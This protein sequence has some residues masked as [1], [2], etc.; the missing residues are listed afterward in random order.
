MK[1]AP[2]VQRQT[3]SGRLTSFLA[4][5]S[6]LS[7]FAFL[8]APAAPPPAAPPWYVKKATWSETMAASRE[9]LARRPNAAA[10]QPIPDFGLADF[11]ATAWIR[12]TRGGAILAKARPEGR[13]E[14][15]GKAF[16]VRGGKLCFDIG[17][18]GAVT[19][20]RTVGDGKWHHV[21]V[22]KAGNT[23]KLF[24][25]GRPDNSRALAAQGDIDGSVL[26]LGNASSDFPQPH[27]FDGD[28]DEIR[29]YPR[30]LSDAELLA[31]AKGTPAAQR[32]QPAAAWPM[33]G[34]TRNAMAGA[35]G[36]V[37]GGQAQKYVA[38]KRGQALHL[39]G[40]GRVVVP[41]ED[42]A[43]LWAQLEADFPS[44][45]EAQQM[46]WEREDGIWNLTWNAGAWGELARRY[47]AATRREGTPADALSEEP[48][49]MIKDEDGVALERKA[50]Y[51]ARAREDYL[52]AL[53]EM[54]L[55]GLKKAIQAMAEDAQSRMPLL[56]GAA[57][58][59]PRQGRPTLALVYDFIST[60]VRSQGAP[61]PA[62][63][64]AEFRRE[65]AQLRREIL[66]KN[67]PLIDF[68]KILFF[69]RKTSQANHYYT[70]FINGCK[71]FGVSLCT[72][73]LRDGKVAEILPESMRG[74]IITHF[75]LSCDARRIVFDYK[76]EIGK[77]FRIYEIGVDGG[78]LRQLTFDPPDEAERIHKY[79]FDKA[80]WH[81][82]D[83]MQPCYL[84]GGAICFVSTRCEYGILCDAPDLFT[85]TILYRMDK[86]GRG[87]TPL[88]NSSVSET[89]PS[90]MND[91]RILYTRW[92]YVDKGGSAVKC[93]WA[94]RPDGTGSVE[95][96]GNDINLPDTFHQ[97]RAIP[98][99]DN[100]FVC[101]G[102]PHMPFGV[103]TVLRLDINHPLRTR[104]PMTYLTPEL[105][106]T[107]EFG[108]TH[109]RGGKWV[110]DLKGPF[111]M[112]PYPLSENF[113]LVT[114]NPDREWSD[115]AGYALT[116]L[117]AFGNKVEIYRDPE[118]SCWEP[119][120][121]RPRP[122]PPVLPSIVAPDPAAPG[123]GVLTLN[124]VYQGMEGVARGTV[125]YL[126]VMEQVP[127]PW[128]SRR[129]WQ[130][131]LKDATYQEHA[132]I[133]LDG[134]L[135]LKVLRGIVPVE[136]DGSA[137]FTVPANRNLYFQALDENFMEVQRMRTYV[138]LRA[139]ES[140]SCIGCHQ[141]RGEAPTPQ[142]PLAMRRAP[143]PLAP[144]PGE[145]A[146][147]V[148]DYRL[149]VQPI[150]DRHCIQCHGGAAPKAGLDLHG[151]MTTLFSASYENLMERKAIKYI[152]E[153]TPKT[154]N[155]DYLPPYSLGAAVS[156]LVKQLKAGHHGVKL[157]RE[158]WVKLTTWADANVQYY[159][160][161]YGKRNLAFKGDPDFRPNPTFEDAISR[162]A[163]QWVK[164][165]HDY[166]ADQ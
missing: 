110:Q 8:T 160:S 48:A 123:E 76:P 128:A 165:D 43:A 143:S 97:G 112:D 27:G 163:P 87:I 26:I 100:L 61:L 13:W 125:K 71:Y 92:E 66:L 21:A 120:P 149:D 159:G 88:S 134:A 19:S 119:V 12:T 23:F 89:F 63:A 49:K 72:L 53:K 83:D 79:R 109:N 64:A 6:L 56:P 40:K 138:T 105:D 29:I 14:P 146:P 25:D 141:G 166:R 94:M 118:S 80:Y 50:Y 127:R 157:T 147:R 145:A 69:K 2:V 4:F 31:E 7:L 122:E 75:D 93:L 133:S 104:Q 51:G 9:A 46:A 99:H 73:T 86:D 111:Y 158:E 60:K 54:N 137:S 106:I 24:A 58:D 132:A 151:T 3:G 121:L 142:K 68:D 65:L 17:W 84:P 91:G 135:G 95:V 1:T 101:I 28:L 140:R 90:V 74:G 129:G 103:G 108:F 15:Q 22:A 102:A 114:H 131:G 155:I 115:V 153:L 11:T 152:G 10:A 116:L 144:Q 39:D 47:A 156:P 44:P 36:A 35:A 18:V 148:I 41:V 62:A 96:Y 20:K 32:V 113:Y 38:G 45:D 98:G 82:T 30:A 161:Y 55:E 126:R 33:D 130:D 67:N 42:F 162:T 124:D 164:W 78:G 107:T 117:D 57:Q 52:K 136:A 34:D 59:H 70:D 150:W 16:F 85:T 154:G 139:G 77:G 81:H 5:Y 37:G